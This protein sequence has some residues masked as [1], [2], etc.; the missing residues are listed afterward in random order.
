MRVAM[1]ATT[2]PRPSGGHR[3]FVRASLALALTLGAAVEKAFLDS[4]AALPQGPLPP[5][6]VGRPAYSSDQPLPADLDPDMLLEEL[7]SP[8]AAAEFLQRRA[9]F[10]ISPDLWSFVRDYRLSIAEFQARGW[11]GDCNDLT[12][13]ICEVGHRHG[14]RMGVLTLWPQQWQ[15]RLTKEWHQVAVVCLAKNRRYLIFDNGVP[16]WWE[17]S[18]EEYA[19]SIDKAVLPIGGM[20]RWQPTR[21]NPLARF[22][23]HLRFNTD[24]DETPVPDPENGGPPLI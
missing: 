8:M 17:A 7:G 15:D 2:G 20:L 1:Q 14:Y 16:I 24:L 9:R 21:P 11:S 10:V 12:G 6:V 19:R 18:I 5:P 22:L 13:V 4:T 3:S 23:D